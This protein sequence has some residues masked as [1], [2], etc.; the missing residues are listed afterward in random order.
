MDL[1]FLC[2]HN[3]GQA[4]EIQ[5]SILILMDLPFLSPKSSRQSVTEVRFNPYSNGSSFFIHGKQQSFYK[6]AFGFNPYSNGS[7]F[8]ISSFIL[9]FDTPRWFQ[10]LF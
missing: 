4:I 5:V 8:F 9:V 10:S 1:P 3:F 7:S 2:I 6:K